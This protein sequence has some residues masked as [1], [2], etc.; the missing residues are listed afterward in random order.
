MAGDVYTHRCIY[1]CK[2]I[3]KR[4]TTSGF[5]YL[6]VFLMAEDLNKYFYKG[7]YMNDRWAYKK[8]SVLTSNQETANWNYSERDFPGGLVVRT[9]RFHCRA[10][11]SIPGGRTE[12][13]QVV[14]PEKRNKWFIGQ[15]SEQWQQ[16][17][18]NQ[19]AQ[20]TNT[21]RPKCGISKLEQRKSYDRIDEMN[22]EFTDG[23]G[24]PWKCRSK[25][26]TCSEL[27][28]IDNVVSEK[29]GWKGQE[30]LD[31]CLFF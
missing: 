27:W 30:R 24:S 23:I 9:L 15:H 16:I 22:R 11:G 1:F 26:T 10:T 12:I 29:D 8:Y 17:L 2:S 4:L 3:I 31:L 21:Q 18:K 19:M 6:L 25:G 20:T 7:R 13:L 14:Q 28:K 5:I